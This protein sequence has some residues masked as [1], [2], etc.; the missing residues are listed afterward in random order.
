MSRS[1]FMRS[2]NDWAQVLLGKSAEPD[3]KKESKG[4]FGFGG[5]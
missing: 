2:L 4:I 5:R 1:E 3:K